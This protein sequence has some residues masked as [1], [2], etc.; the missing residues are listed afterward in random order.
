MRGIVLA[1]ALLTLAPL[2]YAQAPTGGMA[3]PPGQGTMGGQGAMGGMSGAGQVGM[4]SGM[5]TAQ[6][7]PNNCGTPDEPKP[8]P[9]MPR[10]PLKYY[11]AN[12]Q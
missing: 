7:D 4:E 6:P 2:S 10:H 12:K 8:C 1:T 5:A 11:P 3:P 9:P